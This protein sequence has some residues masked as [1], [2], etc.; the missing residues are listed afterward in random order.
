MKIL[1]EIYD[2]VSSIVIAFALALF[3]NIFIFQP[4][5]VVGSSMQPTLENHNYIIISK[6]SH[7]MRSVPDYNDIVIV[8]SRIMRERTWKDDLTEPLLTYLAV[9][10]K[11]TVQP[12]DIWV[13]RVI[14]K[15]GD[16]LEIKDGKIYRNGALLNE[17]YI[18]ETMATNGAKK[19][20]VPENHVFVMGDN[21]NNSMDSRII[22]PIPIDHVLGNMVLKVGL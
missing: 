5:E 11:S 9:I 17:T 15:P 20:T 22:G 10:K 19:I 13:K 6:I 1:N 16:E 14:G 18:K 21:R 4:T 8:D 12:H 3:I 2:W 7:A